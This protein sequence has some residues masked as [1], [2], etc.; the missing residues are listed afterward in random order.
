[1]AQYHPISRSEIEEFLIPQGFSEVS[2]PGVRELVYGRRM[3]VQSP[4]T[5]RIYTGIDPSGAS[6]AVGED[7]IRVAAFW[8]PGVDVKPKKIWTSK[9]VHRVE[10]WR[11][12]LQ[13][14][15]DSFTAPR[16]C[17]DCGAPMVSRKSRLMRS[18]FLGCARY[19]ECNTT[20]DE[21]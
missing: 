11:K 5:L 4:I 14:R 3:D 16:Q 10:G 9:R 6:R 7:A 21:S 1:M 19:P 8:R 18:P 20:L 2:L 15:I 17:P 12:N 13:D